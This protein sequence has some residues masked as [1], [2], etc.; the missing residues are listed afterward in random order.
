M[1]VCLSSGSVQLKVHLMPATNRFE[2]S[3]NGNLAV[4]GEWLLLPVTPRWKRLR[5]PPSFSPCSPCG[6][7][8]R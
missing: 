3:E 2:V 6:L 1:T 5:S 4:S 8:A 7:Q